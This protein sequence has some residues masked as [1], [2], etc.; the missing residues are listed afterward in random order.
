MPGFIKLQQQVN[1]DLTLMASNIRV[2]EKL[3]A[4]KNA[5]LFNAK[6]EFEVERVQTRKGQFS[7]G[8]KKVK[9]CLKSQEINVFA[10]LNEQIE[11]LTVKS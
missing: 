9:K 2:T 6:A 1:D 5:E 4:D 8:D 3:T 11:K 10:E 7:K